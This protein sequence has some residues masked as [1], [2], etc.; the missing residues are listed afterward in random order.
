HGEPCSVEI[1]RGN[2]SNMPVWWSSDSFADSSLQLNRQPNADILEHQRKRQLEV[3]CA[4]LQDMME[5]QGYSAEEIEEKVNSFRMMLQEK[6][7]PA[8]ASTERPTVTETHALAAANQQKNDRLR[9]AF[10]IASDYVDGSSFHADRKEK[11]KEKRE[12]ERLERERQ[13]QQK[14]TLLE[15]SDESDSPPKKRSRKKKKKNKS[16]DR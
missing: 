12:Q 14:Y 16:R 8:P 10:G 6:E 4:E 7:E 3:K 13:Q 2:G 5:E 1:V 11:E 9:A 15:D